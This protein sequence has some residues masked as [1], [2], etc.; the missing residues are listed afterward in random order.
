[1]E[2]SNKK[3]EPCGQ[4]L[5]ETVVAQSGLPDLIIRSELNEI[6][7]QSAHVPDELTLE[8]LRAAMINYLEKINEDLTSEGPLE[9]WESEQYW[10]C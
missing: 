6:I 4:E 5:I 1:M 8:Q 10:T 3:T 7:D 9:S 2:V